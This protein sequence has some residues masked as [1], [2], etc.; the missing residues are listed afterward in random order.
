MLDAES[1]E[2]ASEIEPDYMDLFFPRTVNET[3]VGRE[4]WWSQCPSAARRTVLTWK[5]GGDEIGQTN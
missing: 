5:K 4:V 2:P 1:A 3:S